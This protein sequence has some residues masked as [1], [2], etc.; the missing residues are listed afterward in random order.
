M[1]Q[2]SVPLFTEALASIVLLRSGPFGDGLMPS[3]LQPHNVRAAP[4]RA[5]P[6]SSG[7]P[8]GSAEICQ[9]PPTPPSRA[10][11]RRRRAA[12]HR[13]TKPQ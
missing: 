9:V 12:P 5:A 11:P 7:I 6:T 8:P 3:S 10:D 4:R 1:S 2:N 13:S